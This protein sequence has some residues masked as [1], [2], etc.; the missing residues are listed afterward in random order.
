MLCK[1][2]CSASDFWRI[3][4]DDVNSGRMASCLEHNHERHVTKSPG[5]IFFFLAEGLLPSQEWVCLMEFVITK[6]LATKPS[7]SAP[8]VQ[9]PDAEISSVQSSPHPHN[10][11][12]FLIIV[13]RHF[14]NYVHKYRK[15][16]KIKLYIHKDHMLHSLSYFQRSLYFI[17]EVIIS[18][19]KTWFKFSSV[20]RARWW[21]KY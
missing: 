8:L 17:S 3:L 12:W 21:I 14:R 5:D 13:L 18:D 4:L 11:R 15:I 19:T 16:S 6:N 2:F 20:S 10:I 7:W 9:E 1:I